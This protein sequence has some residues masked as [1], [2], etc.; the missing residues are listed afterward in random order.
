MSK[1]IEWNLFLAAIFLLPYDAVPHIMPS[2][3]RPI[4]VYPLAILG[5]LA[6]IAYIKKGSID[7]SVVLIFKGMLFNFVFLLINIWL[8]DSKLKF[9]FIFT[10]VMGFFSFAGFDYGLKL[11]K[12]NQGNEEYVYS[13]LNLLGKAYYIPIIVGFLE[14]IQVVLPFN[15]RSLFNAIFGGAQYNRICMTSGE[16]SWVSMQLGLFIIVF[17]ILYRKYKKKIYIG[18]IMLLA[19]IFLYNVSS[20][21]IITCVVTIIIFFIANS[22]MNKKIYELIRSIVAGCLII[23][24]MY[25]GMYF[26][27]QYL[28]QAYYT[29]RL[30]QIFDLDQL[31]RW[32]GSAFVRIIYPYIG[33]LMF[34]KRPILGYGG[35]NYPAYFGGYIRDYYPWA[36]EMYG[37]VRAH[38]LQQSGSVY[39]L[40]VRLLAE[41]GSIGTIFYMR[42]IFYICKKITR[43]KGLDCFKGVL[44]MLLYIL[45]VPIQFD[46]LTYVPFWLILAFV[47][48][49]KEE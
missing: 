11:L 39:C 3:Y 8:F 4:S 17:G 49:L 14:L 16:A 15:F 34:L 2:I 42:P 37:E 25:F 18:F 32:D 46:S 35:G 28:P 22:V 23:L 6:L 47:N 24:V 9:D 30:K 45:C 36:Y 26:I 31:I 20:Q 29:N 12:S 5:V 40:Y 21:G 13:F 43:I 1:K 48:N 33:I 7:K 19:L 44:V 41:L 38:I 10:Y 27:I